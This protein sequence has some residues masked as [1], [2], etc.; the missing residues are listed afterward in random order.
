MEMKGAIV[1]K[2]FMDKDFL[3]TTKTAKELYRR[4]AEKTPIFDWHCHLSPKEIYENKRPADIAELWL[5]GD[6]YKWRLMRSCGVSEDYITGTKPNFEKFK[7]FASCLPYAV[8]NPMYHWTHLELQRYFGVEET[9]SEKTAQ[10]I[11]RRCNE[12]IRAGGFTPRE[13]IEKSNVRCVCTTDDPADTLEYHKL[14]QN[15]TDFKCRVLPAFR[16][17]K[18]LGIEL[19]AFIPWIAAME[20]A[21]RREIHTF[22]ELK[23]AL[24][25]RMDLFDA[26]GCR[27][28]DHAFA[29]VPYRPA[30]DSEVEKIFKIGLI[31][32]TLTT[33]ETDKYRT[34]LLR[35]LG[36]EYAKRGWVMELH[37]GAMRNNNRRMFERLGPDTGFDS[38]DDREIAE[39][40]SGLLDA[41]ERKGNLP[42]TVL[43]TLNPKDN[44][45]LGAML[46]NFQSDEIASKIQFGS[47]WWFNDNYDGMRE[48]MK[49]LANLGVLGKFVGMV[50][51]SRSFLSYPRHEY[52]RR[53]LCELI[54]D[55]VEEGKY[56][57]DL[58]FLSQMVADIAFYNAER[59]FNLDI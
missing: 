56:P 51:D 20:K 31:G 10:D 1:L 8:G 28:S 41:L 59:Y 26:L 52:F 30:T 25:E 17:D 48:Q 19:P 40:L 21:V 3:L 47:A 14:L 57:C 6:H 38:I 16:P 32:G 53:I 36:A 34:A 45:V 55:W 11:Y 9:L 54:G 13:L 24:S 49:T 33:E 7:A 39:G 18:A 58:D 50:T 4:G 35:F 5:S 42:K 43:F 12:K 27:A 46:G 44:Y 37:I 22:A 23:A 29:Y 15:E 2:R